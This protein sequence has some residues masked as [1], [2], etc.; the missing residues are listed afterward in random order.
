MS[1]F[2]LKILIQETQQN[3]VC[4][5]IIFLQFV[6]NFA[7]LNSNQTNKTKQLLIPSLTRGPHLA[8]EQR[9]GGGGSALPC[10]VPGHTRHR[11]AWRERGGRGG[12][13]ASRAAWRARA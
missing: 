7:T 2:P 10:P 4:I 13:P 5:F 12:W 6:M 1:I 11:R 3:S 8:V 9:E